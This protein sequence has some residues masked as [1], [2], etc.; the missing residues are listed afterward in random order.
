VLFAP[1]RLTVKADVSILILGI[2]GGVA[3]LAEHGIHKPRVVGSIPT[4]A[5]FDFYILIF[6]VP[7]PPSSSG[8]GRRV[9]NPV[10]GVRLPLGVF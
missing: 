8:L 2:S 1:S 4:A 10:T 9:L 5:N 3:Q 7:L 6:D